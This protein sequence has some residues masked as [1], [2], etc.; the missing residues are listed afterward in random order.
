MSF[1]QRTKLEQDSSAKNEGNIGI[2]P[3]EKQL[4]EETV[5]TTR[6]QCMAEIKEQTRDLNKVSRVIEA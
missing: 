5:K 1:P 6:E 2:T 3:F 4:C